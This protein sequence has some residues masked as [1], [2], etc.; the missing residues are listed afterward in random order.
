[1]AGLGRTAAGAALI[2]IQAVAIGFG[3]NA[4][5]S[6]GLPLTRRPLR[7]THRLAA[8]Q[9]VFRTPPDTS[10]QVAKAGN[11]PALAVPNSTAPVAVS[12][13]AT[14]PKSV[15]AK[16]PAPGPATTPKPTQTR[17]K[18]KPAPAAK[19]VE[20][21]FT[22]LTDAEALWRNKAALFVDA[23]NR[24]DYDLE[25]IAGA[26]SLTEGDFDKLYNGALGA[27][28]KGRTIVTYCSDP[29]CETAIKLADA[30][31]E[32]GHTHVLIL[33]EGLPGW[34]QAGYETDKQA[35]P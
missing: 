35:N 32:R 3:A 5:S 34:K 9:E 24:E 30:L 31:V 15:P 2:V 8:R 18:P 1:M 12:K 29:E 26:V 10:R 23:R 21:L 19:K 13:P 33:L 14:E 7:E 17:T 20:A 16:A 6:H 22:S 28:A 25:H 11:E 4:I 27:V